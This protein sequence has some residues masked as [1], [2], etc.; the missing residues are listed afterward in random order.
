MTTTNKA[1]MLSALAVSLVFSSC[2]D[3]KDQPKQQ[4]VQ[5]SESAAAKRVAGLGF[6]AQ[7]PADTQLLGAVYDPAEICQSL[8]NT[9]LARIISKSFQEEQDKA[10]KMPT[11]EELT[12]PL[13][14]SK[15][16]EEILPL[17]GDEIVFGQYGDV[18]PLLNSWGNLAATL[19]GTV[20]SSIQLGQTEQPFSNETMASL[21]EEAAK[22]QIIPGVVALKNSPEAYNTLKTKLAERMLEWSK[23]LDG[24]SLVEEKFA[25]T[26]FSG[27]KIDGTKLAE[28]IQ[29]QEGANNKDKSL[30]PLLTALLSGK[31]AYLLMG[32][33]GDYTVCF[34]V[35]DPSQMKLAE[36]PDKSVGAN[37]EF[38][39]I[40]R[41]AG[42]KPFTVGFA[43]EAIMKTIMENYRNYNTAY[44]SSLFQMVTAFLPMLGVEDTD[45]IAAS[46]NALTAKLSA[47]E[48]FY[49]QADSALGLFGQKDRGY[50]FDFWGLSSATM[51]MSA[52]LPMTPRFNGSDVILYYE[53]NPSE[54]YVKLSW[55]LLDQIGDTAVVLMD[56]AA[57]SQMFKENP[58]YGMMLN[59]VK[60][61]LID[62]GK[63]YKVLFS[64]GLGKDV[65]LAVTQG[66]GEVPV[67]LSFLAPVKNRTAV[68]EGWNG[69]RKA[70]N[71]V[72]VTMLGTNWDASLPLISQEELNTPGGVSAFYA[73]APLPMMDSLSPATALNDKILVSGTSAPAVKKLALSPEREPA[74]EAPRGTTF[75]IRME[76]LARLMAQVKEKN[77]D[78][79]D[80][81]FLI[82]LIGKDFKSIEAGVELIDGKAKGTFHIITE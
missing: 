70:V 80:A 5:Q 8:R 27:V 11:L 12:A 20:G 51:D 52:P 30:Q 55:N 68:M 62:L 77:Q 25:G 37:P 39:F 47:V 59:M 45:K 42:K 40:D 24:L 71:G 34:S 3:K 16:L 7:L 6:V 4:G 41:Y 2:G 15:E 14:A 50:K 22:I 66:E 44:T 29:K 79:K 21:K 35:Q 78:L 56:A 58:S 1:L 28:S 48:N 64:Q 43:T 57:T 18:Q 82:D 33:V 9:F 54:E 13:P 26:A 76:P 65:T 73:C 81:S 19:A 10:F 36:S 23:N 69:M 17:L 49:Y 74:A 61:A 38:A 67:N 72:G 63:N 53:L 75:S 32:R 60:P 31:N 46:L